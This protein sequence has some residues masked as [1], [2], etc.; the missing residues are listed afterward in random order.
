MPHDANRRTSRRFS[1]TCLV[2]I[3]SASFLP[4]RPSSITPWS[5]IEVILSTTVFLSLWAMFACVAGMACLTYLGW[6]SR[7]M[8]TAIAANTTTATTVQMLPD[9]LGLGVA[10]E[11]TFFEVRRAREN[12]GGWVGVL[13]ASDTETS[14]SV[15]LFGV[16]PRRSLPASAWAWVGPEPIASLLVAAMSWP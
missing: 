8:R 7:Y 15:G 14:I 3:D 12:S 5:V 16:S 2:L 9:L 6:I 1:T 4:S 10:S 11:T 13:R